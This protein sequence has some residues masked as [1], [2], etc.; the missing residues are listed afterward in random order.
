MSITKIINQRIGYLE[1]KLPNRQFLRIHRAYII[2]TDKIKS[3][4]TSVIEVG[5]L[6][7]PIGR[8]YKTEVMKALGI[9][10]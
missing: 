6:E 5:D 2:A 10:E 7:L 8:Q 9:Q 4:S 1:E 3:F